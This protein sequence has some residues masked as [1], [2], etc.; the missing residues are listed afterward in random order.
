MPIVSQYA[1]AHMRGV[2]I[3]TI[4]AAARRGSLP[5]TI[6]RRVDVDLADAT[7]YARHQARVVDAAG[8]IAA[9]QRRDHAM[10]TSLAAK[11]QMTRRQVEQLRAR[12][13]DRD[14]LQ[15][16]INRLVDQ[17][18]VSLPEIAEGA[19]PLDLALLQAAVEVITKD[20]RTLTA[21]AMAVTRE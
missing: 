3:Q 19:D 17:L 8:A 14:A 5:L 16:A 6:D 13:T 20:L 2:T 9:E 11:I 18:F 4:T 10:L 1:Y 15:A 21:E 7:W 12:L